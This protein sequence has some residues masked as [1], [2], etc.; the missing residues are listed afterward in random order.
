[1]RA[2]VDR[3]ALEAGQ[4]P[5]RVA[6]HAHPSSAISWRTAG[7][8]GRSPIQVAGYGEC[9]VGG[10][11][12]VS[13]GFTDPVSAGMSVFQCTFFSTHEEQKRMMGRKFYLNGQA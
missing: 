4:C 6:S 7:M 10:S 11:V 12:E 9:S 3:I 2:Q 5:E 1:M 13:Y 8:T